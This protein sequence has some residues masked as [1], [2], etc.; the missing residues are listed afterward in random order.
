MYLFERH[1]QIG[2]VLEDDEEETVKD[3][4]TLAS[5]YHRMTRHIPTA[6]IL[7]GFHSKVKSKFLVSSSEGLLE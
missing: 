7:T 5:E 3:D 2:P 6:V 4:E 1:F